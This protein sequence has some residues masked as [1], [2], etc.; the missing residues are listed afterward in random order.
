MERYC[1]SNEI[2]AKLYPAL[3]N[4]IFDWAAKAPIN[5]P[6]LEPLFTLIRKKYPYE[7][8]CPEIFRWRNEARVLKQSEYT[9]LVQL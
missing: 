2:D 8:K 4:H 9:N 6:L 1:L 7:I 5:Q 3:I